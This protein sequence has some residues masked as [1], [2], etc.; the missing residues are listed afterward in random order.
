MSD[1]IKK[2]HWLGHA[3]FRIQTGGKTIYIDPWN[4]KNPVAA[5]YILVTH[6]HYDHFSLPDIEKIKKEET[7]IICP[8]E[9]SVQLNGPGVKTVKPGDVLKLEGITVETVPAYNTGKSFHTKESGKAGYVIDSG[10]ERI[11]HAGDTDYIDEMNGLENITVA[12]LPAGGTYTMDAGQA[13]KAAAAISPEAVI[14]MHYGEVAGSVKDAE[15][16]KKICGDKV[17]ILKSE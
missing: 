3:S 15:K 14:P 5:D 2:I 11:Y 6:S 9:V 7:V 10:E 8:Q 13:A 12:L 1:A 4:I 16:L 17:I